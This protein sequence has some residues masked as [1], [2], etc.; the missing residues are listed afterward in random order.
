MATYSTW[1]QTSR[2]LNAKIDSLASQYTL[3]NEPKFMN[4]TFDFYNANNIIDSKDGWKNIEELEHRLRYSITQQMKFFE[5]NVFQVF[6]KHIKDYEMI[7]I[8]RQKYLNKIWL[9]FMT[10]ESQPIVRTFVDRLHNNILDSNVNTKVFPAE[11]MEQ[12]NIIIIQDFIDSNFSASR[13]KDTITDSWFDWILHWLWYWRTWFKPV[14]EY[15]EDRSKSW[16]TKDK[17]YNLKETHAMMDYVPRYC[18]FADPTKD[19]YSQPVTYRNWLSARDALIRL[20]DFTKLWKDH[21]SVI[22]KQPRYF[23]KSDYSKTKL[24]RYYDHCKLDLTKYNER[25]IYKVRDENDDI[26]YIEYWD[27]ENLAILLNWYIVYDYKNPLWYG[28]HPFKAIS[29]GK[30][31]GTWL[32]SWVADTLWWIQNMYNTYYNIVFDLAKFTAWPMR[33]IEGNLQ[34]E[35]QEWKDMMERKPFSIKK[36]FWDW[37][38]KL[39]SMPKPDEVNFKMLSDMLDMANFV[40]DPASYNQLKAQSRSAADSHYR[41]EELKNSVK[42][43]MQSFNKAMVRTI[44]DWFILAKNNLPNKFRFPTRRWDDWKTIV[45]KELNLDDLKNW[46]VFETEFDSVANINRVLERSQ[47][48]ELIQNM[49]LIWE[50]PITW[51]YLLNN[52]KI[53][54]LLWDLYNQPWE[55]GLTSEQYKD[56]VVKAQALKTSI[57][58]ELWS[59]QWNVEGWGGQ[60]QWWGDQYQAPTPQWSQLVP[61]NPLANSPDQWAVPQSMEEMFWV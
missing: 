18:I 6:I 15:F 31:S 44:E 12:E 17:I 7:W 23:S 54:K 47:L 9:D 30:M 3:A 43:L 46:M 39:F 5:D 25:D 14:K 8:D 32:K 57:S 61:T 36:V 60:Y 37:E 4:P 11:K 58:E 38:I 28:R 2:D 42:S 29:S 19:F 53:V 41:Y 52:R 34:I 35:W 13:A 22:L 51:E 10:N 49:K 50:D 26:E 59:I 16:D 20:S 40:V 24:L 55:F 21:L 33:Q 45:W 1:W 56:I 48:M 27:W